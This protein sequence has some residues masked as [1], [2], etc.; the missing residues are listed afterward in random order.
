M[1]NTSLH[2]L[3]LWLLG[4]GRKSNQMVYDL[5]NS[6]ELFQRY[7]K[8]PDFFGEVYN[9]WQVLKML[10]KTFHLIDTSHVGNNVD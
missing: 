10:S 4:R 5:L 9:F 3:W 1:E 6:E 8:F 7:V 2:Y